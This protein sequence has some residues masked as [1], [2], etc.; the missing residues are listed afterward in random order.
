MYG[1]TEREIERQIAGM[2]SEDEGEIEA[3]VLAWA[4]ADLNVELAVVRQRIVPG[5]QEGGDG[6]E[7]CGSPGLE[8]L[9]ASIGGSGA[10]E[11]GLYRITKAPRAIMPLVAASEGSRGSMTSVSSHESRSTKLRHTGAGG[12]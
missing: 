4:A 10:G 11:C 8:A 12:G 5:Q 7:R 2:G 3:E 6:C 1:Q 9:E